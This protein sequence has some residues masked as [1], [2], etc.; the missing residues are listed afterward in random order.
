MSKFVAKVVAWAKTP[1][2]KRDVAIAIAFAE[3]I[4]QAAKQVGV[5]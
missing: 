1:Q 3:A 5:A 2:A 4:W